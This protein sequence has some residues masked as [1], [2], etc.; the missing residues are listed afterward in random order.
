MTTASLYS[1]LGGAPVPRRTGRPPLPEVVRRDL[2]QEW[3]RIRAARPA[4]KKAL[5]AQIRA[6]FREYQP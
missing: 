4:K 1:T 5:L 6:I 2:E 3:Q